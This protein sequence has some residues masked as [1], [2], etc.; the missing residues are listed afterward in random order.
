MVTDIGSARVRKAL[1]THDCRGGRDHSEIGHV[2]LAQALAATLDLDYAGAVEECRGRTGLYHFPRRTL[3]GHDEVLRL[4]VA[5]EDDLFGGWVAEPFMA[6][7]AIVHPLVSQGAVAPPS[8][9]PTF[10]R[11]VEEVVL[12]G[13]TVFDASDAAEAGRRLLARGALRLK[14]VLAEGARGQV[15]VRTQDELEKALAAVLARHDVR[16]GLVLEEN[17]SDVGTGS[18]GEVRAADLTVGYFGIQSLTDDNAGKKVYGGSALYLIRGDMAALLNHPLDARARR[19]VAAARVFDR[20][21]DANLAGFFAS[22]R[23]YDIIFGT[24]ADGGERLAVLEQSWR[25]GGATG[26]EIAA[27]ALFRADPRIAAVRARTVERYGDAQVPDGAVVHYRGDDPELGPLVKYT[28][29]DDVIRAGDRGRH[30][31]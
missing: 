5:C 16:D 2:S 8:W 30:R 29:V 4:A 15:V 18:V 19:C 22:R 1:V 21:A 17:L 12:D 13:L 25:V 14:P 7:K 9:V 6:T 11:K 28:V 20:A 23:N 26:A 31:P 24:A 10:A 3:C 27:L